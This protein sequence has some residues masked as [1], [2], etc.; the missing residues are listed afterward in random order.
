MPI[1]QKGIKLKTLPMLMQQPNI[2]LTKELYPRIAAIYNRTG[3]S[4]ERN[5]RSVIHNTWKVHDGYIWQEYLPTDETGRTY[6]P[7]NGDFFEMLLHVV[8][9]TG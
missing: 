3:Q 1:L 7:S 8:S 6:R 2:Q 9:K 5:I 4:V